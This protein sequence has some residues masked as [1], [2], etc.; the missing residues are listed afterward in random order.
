MISPPT[1]IVKGLGRHLDPPLIGLELF[2][3]EETS[4]YS[5]IDTTNS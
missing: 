1:I 2:H 4:T 3:M 5:W